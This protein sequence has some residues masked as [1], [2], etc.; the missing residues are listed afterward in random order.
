MLQKG[1]LYQRSHRHDTDSGLNRFLRD[2]QSGAHSTCGCVET[3]S[4]GVYSK[5]DVHQTGAAVLDQDAFPLADLLV[6]HHHSV[7]DHLMLLQARLEEFY[8]LKVVSDF[9]LA[10]IDFEKLLVCCTHALVSLLE[11][12]PAIGQMSHPQT[13]F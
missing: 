10:Y 4:I 5:I 2:T 13:H 11:A 7:L 6:E 3:V 8:L 12:I 1:A 9:L